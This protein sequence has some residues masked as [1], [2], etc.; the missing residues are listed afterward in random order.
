M[1]ETEET[2]VIEK[3]TTFV[4]CN[5]ISL[6]SQYTDNNNETNENDKHEK[7]KIVKDVKEAHNNI[8]PIRNWYGH[9][10]P[11]GNDVQDFVTQVVMVENIVNLKRH[12]NK[13]QQSMCNMLS[14]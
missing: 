6:Q 2:V 7:D 1:D 9:S 12:Y 5:E 3:D 8:P 10:G 11:T 14:F 13:R 4:D